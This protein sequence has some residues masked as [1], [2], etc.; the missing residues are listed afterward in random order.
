MSGI[1]GKDT[2][3]EML[4]RKM[5]FAQGFRYRLHVRT[6]PGSPDIVMASRCIAIFVHGCFWHQHVGC[7]FARLPTSRA[8]FW[9][10]KLAANV[11]RDQR[12]VRELLDK[13]WR[14]L[15]VWECA[16]RDP[17][18][19]IELPT[20]MASWIRSSD[21]LGELRGFPTLPES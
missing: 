1:Q 2:R 3:P 17:D 16:L 12:A 5:L 15:V 9:A 18:S 4:V 21:L 8:E 20:A 13:G 6:L 11:A 14:V 10:A 7:K 19:F